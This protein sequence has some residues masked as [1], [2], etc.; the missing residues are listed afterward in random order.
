MT[1]LLQSIFTRLQIAYRVRMCH[2]IDK[3]AKS[4]PRPKPE[5][6]KV[7]L[8]R[9]DAIGDYLLF[10]NFIEVFANS[11]QYKGKQLFFCGNMVWKSL[12]DALDHE[13]F[14][15]SFWLNR[16]QFFT[17]PFYRFR[18]QR[19]IYKAGFA[20]AIAPT[21]SRLLLYDDAIVNASQAT[22]RI[23]NEG[24]TDNIIPKEK[25]IADTYYTQLL[26]AQ[27]AVLFEFDRN[28]EF[29]EALLQQKIVLQR[30]VVE[31]TKLPT[32]P[33]FIQLPPKQVKVL[34]FVGGSEVHKRWAAENFA[35]LANFLHHTYKAAIYLIGDTNDLPIAQKVCDLQ[36]NL[37]IQNL[38]GKTN[39]LELWS[40]LQYADLLVANE[41]S[42]VH[43]AATL[44]VPTIC[45]SNNTWHIGRFN[46]YP[47]S[48]QLPIHYIF[49]FEIQ[50]IDYEEITKKYTFQNRLSIN[51]IAI[52]KVREKIIFKFP[53]HS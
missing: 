46:P 36:P 43:L 33:T 11:P 14:A 15:G 32:L 41:S 25:K 53:K 2:L 44:A 23:G 20:V 4:L 28:K 3:L 52:E 13:Y 16:K 40:L 26:P 47:D 37:P 17:N 7:L 1:E 5:G 29:F 19:A 24:N 38:A 22:Q 39:L 8:I 30:P 6:E 35:A 48:M 21:F 31:I 50:G 49:P 45:L 34:L 51:D 12:F 9:L 10:R 18:I 27:P 42:G